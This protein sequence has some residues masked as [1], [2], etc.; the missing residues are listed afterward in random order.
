MKRFLLAAAA[1]AM[2]TVPVAS[3]FHGSPYVAHGVA[4]N[5]AGE[6]HLVDV[7]W[8]GWWQ[9]TYTVRLYDVPG[10]WIVDHTFLGAEANIGGGPIAS[11]WEIF[12][13]HGF[14]IDPSVSFDIRGFQQI[15]LVP[16]AQQMV[17]GGNYQDW[18]LALVVDGVY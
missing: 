6:A 18:T 10:V 12:L 16:Q 5:L 3:A 4:V 9:Q 7:S 1:L 17:Y 11:V 15:L 13:Y 2:L 8:N 14:S